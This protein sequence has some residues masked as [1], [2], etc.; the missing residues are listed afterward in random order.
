VHR[1]SVHVR[2]QWR[3]SDKA[4]VPMRW[5]MSGVGLARGCVRPRSQGRRGDKPI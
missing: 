5:T 2:G 4:I 3:P 1:R